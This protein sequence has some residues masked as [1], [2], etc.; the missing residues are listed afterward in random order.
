MKLVSLSLISLLFVAPTWAQDHHASHEN[1]AEHHSTDHGDHVDH[2][3][4]E[5]HTN[6]AEDALIHTQL[7]HTPEIHQALEA[8]GDA[9]VVSVLGVVCDF[10]A[11]AMD[12]TFSKRE[13]IAAV[14]VDLDHKTLNLVFNPDQS[15][16][17]DSIRKLVKKA[18]YRAAELTFIPSMNLN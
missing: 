4:H 5:H 7:T 16:D 14:Y 2:A 17:E 18:G 12:K 1:L 13:E 15:I 11:T 3:D 9:V 10:C 6:H 8:G